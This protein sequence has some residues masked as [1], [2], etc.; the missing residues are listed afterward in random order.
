MAIPPPVCESRRAAS[1]FAVS[2]C[3]P[4]GANCLMVAATNG[5]L[6]GLSRLYFALSPFPIYV[7]PQILKQVAP[8]LAGSSADSP[9]VAVEPGRE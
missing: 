8:K 2:S 6:R 5:M 1:F 4:Q 3:K 9:A 7:S